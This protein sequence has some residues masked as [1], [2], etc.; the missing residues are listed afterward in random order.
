LL[1]GVKA[2]SDAAL[3]SARWNLLG[4]LALA[5]L[6]LPVRRARRPRSWTKSKSGTWSGASYLLDLFIDR[7]RAGRFGRGAARC[8]GRRSRPSV[9]QLPSVRRD[10]SLAVPYRYPRPRVA[11]IRKLPTCSVAPRS[12]YRRELL[13]AG[14]A[15]RGRLDDKE[16]L[17]NAS[18]SGFPK[19]L[20]LLRGG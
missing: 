8:R 4:S 13:S 14:A 18:P 9:A 19:A 7:T 16:A 10:S 3:A 20:L 6:V 2:K 1:I 5:L 15:S 17:Q 11:L 12:P